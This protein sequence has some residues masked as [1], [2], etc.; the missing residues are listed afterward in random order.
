MGATQSHFQSPPESKATGRLSQELNNQACPPIAAPQGVNDDEIDVN[1]NNI[2]VTVDDDH[3][4]DVS[5]L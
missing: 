5:S 1:N 3:S 4:E 2:P